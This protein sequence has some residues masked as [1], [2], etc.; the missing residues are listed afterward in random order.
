MWTSYNYQQIPINSK[1]RIHD[2]IIRKVISTKYL[3]VTINCNLS[4]SD[5]IVSICNKARSTLAFMQRNLKQCSNTLRI[6]TNLRPIWSPH[7]SYLWYSKTWDDTTHFVYSDFSWYIS[8]TSL[9]NRLQWTT[10]QQWRDI[11]KVIMFYTKCL[12][13]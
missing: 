3:G 12:L 7:N 10:L 1:Y 13:A 6:Q 11:N 9:V 8:V 5:H 2:N 4:W